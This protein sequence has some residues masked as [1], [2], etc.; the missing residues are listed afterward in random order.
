MEIS[1]NN[2]PEFKVIANGPL[3]VKGKIT[4]INTNGEKQ[5]LE[6]TWLCRCGNSK[7]KPFCDGS[8]KTAG[9]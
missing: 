7:N 1:N 3:H 6:E 4:L 5:E 2:I 9:F 8:H